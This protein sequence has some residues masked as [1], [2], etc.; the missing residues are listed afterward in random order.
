[1]PIIPKTPI[2]D[3]IKA[4]QENSEVWTARDVENLKAQQRRQIEAVRLAGKVMRRD[5]VDLVKSQT[6]KFISETTYFVVQIIQKEMLSL[7]K[8]MN[9]Y[10]REIHDKDLKIMECCTKLKS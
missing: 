6:K 3:K 8:L 10:K 7:L 5:S 4:F 1:M 9:K 2:R